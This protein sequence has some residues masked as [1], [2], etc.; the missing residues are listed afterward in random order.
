VDKISAITAVGLTNRTTANEVV[1][2][3][4]CFLCRRFH[5]EGSQPKLA[6]TSTTL[7]IYQPTTPRLYTVEPT[8]DKVSANTVVGLAE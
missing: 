3:L 7:T 6:T 4:G 5:F 1:V 8:V 2:L